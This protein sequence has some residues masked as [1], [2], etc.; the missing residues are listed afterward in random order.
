MRELPVVRSGGVS[1]LGTHREV[2]DRA[3]FD[4]LR[5]DYLP[6]AADRPQ[7]TDTSAAPPGRQALDY[8]ADTRPGYAIVQYDNAG[9]VHWVVGVFGDALSA[10]EYAIDADLTP[11]DVVSATPVV[12]RAP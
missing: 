12:R 5:G 8:C 1:A 6:V 11:Y 10:E 2:E 4:F 3:V 9:R 7:P